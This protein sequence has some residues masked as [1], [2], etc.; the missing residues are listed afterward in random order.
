MTSRYIG[1]EE[2][3]HSFSYAPDWSSGYYSDH[4]TQGYVAALDFGPYSGIGAARLDFSDC[5]GWGPYGVSSGVA[6]DAVQVSS[7]AMPS[8]SGAP[9]ETLNVELDSSF[10]SDFWGSDG[11]YYH[12]GGSLELHLGAE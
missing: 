10:G 5:G 12:S 11:S 7:S 4:Y 6:S 3:D 1:F 8:L 2:E 9:I